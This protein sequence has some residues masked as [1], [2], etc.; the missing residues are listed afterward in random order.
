[1]FKCGKKFKAQI[2]TNRVQHYLG[3]FD[4]EIEAARAYDNHARVSAVI[5]LFI[6]NQLMI[7][8][9]HS[10]AIQGRSGPQ[11]EDKFWLRYQLAGQPECTRCPH[12]YESGLQIS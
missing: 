7:F 4:T 9:G 2:Q 1:M 5:A 6:N 3:L 10:R 11:S 8:V 12:I